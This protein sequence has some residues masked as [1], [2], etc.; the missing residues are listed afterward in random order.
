[1]N[2]EVSAYTGLYFCCPSCG[3]TVVVFIF[4]SH[5]KCEYVMISVRPAGRPSIRTRQSFNVA[6]FSDTIKV[7]KAK[8]SLVVLLIKFYPIIPLSA[9]LSIF[10]GHSFNRKCYVLIRS[11]SNFV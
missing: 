3:T 1:M 4:D 6:I 10:Q 11:G 9:T 2:T 8:F 5:E 7:I